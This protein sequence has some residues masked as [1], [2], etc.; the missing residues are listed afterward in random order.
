MS[1]CVTDG[2][3]PAKAPEAKKK[4]CS[5][6]DDR[7]NVSSKQRSAGA[8][9][10]ACQALWVIYDRCY[11]WIRSSAMAGKVR[12]PRTRRQRYIAYKL[13]STKPQRCTLHQN[14]V[15]PKTFHSRQPRPPRIQK[16]GCKA[17]PKQRPP[18]GSKNKTAKECFFRK[19]EVA[20]TDPN[21]AAARSHFC[22]RSKQNLA[23]EAL[24]A[25][26]VAHPRARV[27]LAPL[28]LPALAIA[29]SWPAICIDL[30]DTLDKRQMR[31][32]SDP[33]APTT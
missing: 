11:I 8:R 18:G 20:K 26:P 31:T 7:H 21:G 3:E 9:A 30:S 22:D 29:C 25:L 2:D 6:F 17:A 12:R 13:I 16:T 33:A 14:N 27:L 4:A 10:V 5:S 24:A 1:Y 15:A 32:R 19:R 23:R 28:T